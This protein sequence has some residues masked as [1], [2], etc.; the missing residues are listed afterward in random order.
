MATDFKLPNLGENIDAGDVVN[1]LV[2]EGDVIAANQGVIEV[3]T[4][5]ATVEVPCPHAGKVTKVHVKTGQSVP[6]GGVIVTIEAGAGAA[7]AASKPA[8]PAPAAAKPAP[9]PSAAASPAIQP[10]PKPA[11]APAPPPAAPSLPA[12]AVPA[13]AAAA[14]VSNDEGAL[15]AA[16]PSVR[17]LA[18]ELG[19]DIARVPGSG[20]GGRITREDVVSAVRHTSAQ[21]AATA[22]APRNANL[23]NAVESRDNYGSV[24]RQPLSKMRKTIA[25]NMVRSTQTIPQL[26]N[27]DD[28]DITELERMRKA[29]LDDYAKSGIKLTMMPFVMKA[30]A[31]ALRMHPVMNA[32][33]DIEKDEIVYKNYVNLGVAVDTDRGLVV[34]VLRDA[35]RLPIPAIAQALQDIAERTRANKFTLEDQSGGTFTI[36]NLGAIGGTYSTPII[37]P[38]QVG[39]LLTGRSRKLPVVLD[40]DKIEARLMMPLSITY[41][42]RLVDGAAAARFMNDVKNFLQVPGRLLLAQ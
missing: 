4:G 28:A 19:I 37:N 13:P 2:K 29:S 20:T 25:A 24:L 22:F 30:V 35:D 23:P 38:P 9:A 31:Q 36:S 18:R 34:P 17:R 40:N 6:V 26:T 14:A 12:Q 15:A 33:L 1:V 41:D 32:S 42:H 3:E 11:A 5:K 16:G 8:A 21:A 39:I 27:F 10:T 7:P